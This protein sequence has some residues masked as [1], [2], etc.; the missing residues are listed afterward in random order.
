MK[1][2]QK[3]KKKRSVKEK[4]QQVAA[5]ELSMEDDDGDS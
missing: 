5:P 3:G 2:K 4:V 1:S